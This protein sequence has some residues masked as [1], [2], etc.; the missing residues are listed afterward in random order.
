MRSRPET[1]YSRARRLLMPFK[2][3][4]DVSASFSFSSKCHFTEESHSG[5]GSGRGPRPRP[6]PRPLPKSR[7]PPRP[8]KPRPPR[9]PRPPWCRPPPW[10]PS[11]DDIVLDATTREEKCPRCVTLG[12]PE[13]RRRHELL[14]RQ[15]RVTEHRSVSDQEIFAASVAILPGTDV[16]PCA[17]RHGGVRFGTCHRRALLRAPSRNH[18]DDVAAAAARGLGGV[19]RGTRLGHA[20]RCRFRARRGG[21]CGV[22]RH[23]E[24]CMVWCG[25][26]DLR[27]Y[28]VGSG[29]Y[30]EFGRACS[31]PPPPVHPPSN[32][33]SPPSQLDHE[34]IHHPPLPF[35]RRRAGSLTERRAPFPRPR[36]R[37]GGSASGTGHRDRCDDEEAVRRV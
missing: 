3:S 21:G 34:I 5:V 24:D 12:P 10:S 8:G 22:A 36:Y 25:V 33:P 14:P 2:S 17:E 7:P 20:R 4:P 30:D 23:G 37:S 18:P 31:T 11:C 32:V 16:R 28:A 15:R 13:T 6:P 9:P 19:P 35:R 1:W 27:F 26:G 29:Q